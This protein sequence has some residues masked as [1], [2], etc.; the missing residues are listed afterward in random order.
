MYAGVPRGDP[1]A[2]VVTVGDA[3]DG[4]VAPS[5]SPTPRARPKSVTY[6]RPSPTKI[7]SGLVSP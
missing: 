3:S 4:A 6:A 2:V 1:D 5:V 7:L